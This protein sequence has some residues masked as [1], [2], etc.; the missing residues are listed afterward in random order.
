MM[1]LLMKR[2]HPVAA[3]LALSLV[4]SLI[5]MAGF[6]TLEPTTSQAAVDTFLV[7]QTVTG[8]ISFMAST[9]DVALSPALAGLTGGTANGR[10]QVRVKTNNS[11][12]YNMTIVFSSSTAMN[13]NG[14]GGY[15]SNYSNT[16]A[17]VPD[18]TFANE[19]YGQFAYAVQA[20]STTDV[21]QTF[22][23]NGSNACNTGSS[24]TA[25]TCWMRPSTTAETIINRTTSTPV[26]GATS[27][28]QFRVH[29]PNSPSPAIPTGTYTA[30][31]TLTALTNP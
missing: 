23:S 2:S 12:G 30:T 4:A 20:S 3:A 15:I 28:V 25:N 29:I 19:T 31:A 13:R 22:R 16:T 24:N 1:Y 9:S 11:T 26:S 6:F 10:T 5:L 27:S 18:Y 8:E 21:D 7:T 14:G 17:A